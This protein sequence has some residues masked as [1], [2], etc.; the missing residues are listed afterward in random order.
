MKLSLRIDQVTNL[1]Q[2]L[3]FLLLIRKNCILKFQIDQIN[4]ISIDQDNLTSTPIIWCTINKKIFKKYEVIAKDNLIGIELNIEPLFQIL[5]NF[6]KSM[7]TTDL[8]IKLTRS[9]N[10]NNNSTST[11]TTSNKRNVYL[12]LQFNNSITMNNEIT[13]SFSIPVDLLRI[14]SLDKIRMPILKNIHLIID[15]NRT[16][17]PLFKRI[18]RYKATEFI[19]IVINKLGELKIKMHDDGKNISLKWKNLLDTCKPEDVDTQ[20]NN[21]DET[22]LDMINDINIKIRIKW[23]NFVSKLLEICDILPFY[24]IDDGCAFHCNVEDE[25]NC[26]MDYYIPGKII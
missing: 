21:R 23:W 25:Q 24:I 20:I 4:I 19:N 7:S 5:K 11:N 1:R 9:D 17:I 18:E 3:G 2:I 22:D 14:S 6:E 8:S 15:M 10:T 13:H 26:S 16:L 12:A